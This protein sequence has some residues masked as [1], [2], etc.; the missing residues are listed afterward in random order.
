MIVISSFLDCS[1]SVLSLGSVSILFLHHHQ[2]TGI[3][4]DSEG[5]ERYAVKGY[6]DEDISLAKVI[7]GRGKNREVDK[8]ERLWKADPPV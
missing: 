7:K 4:S 3:I 5:V 8:Y 6:W 1:P 2:V